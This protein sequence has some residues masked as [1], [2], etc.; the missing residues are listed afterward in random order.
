MGNLETRPEAGLSRLPRQELP[1]LLVIDNADDIRFNYANYFPS[2]ESG[3]ILLT[4]RNPECKVHATVSSKEF[5]DLETEDAITLLLKA[6]SKDDDVN[7]QEKRIS[8]LPVVKAPC[9][10]M[11]PYARLFSIFQG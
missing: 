5:R 6:I 10:I 11:E 1:W 3:H 8:A 4:S 2:G 7:I 9:C